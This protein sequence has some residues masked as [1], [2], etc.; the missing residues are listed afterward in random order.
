MK[1]GKLKRNTRPSYQHY[2]GKLKNQRRRHRL[3]RSRDVIGKRWQV[4]LRRKRTHYRLDLLIIMLSHPEHRLSN[5]MDKPKQSKYNNYVTKSSISKKKVQS[6][7]R[8][9]K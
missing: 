8:R 5:P 3:R 4:A 7:K 1:A 2:R 6:S 9:F